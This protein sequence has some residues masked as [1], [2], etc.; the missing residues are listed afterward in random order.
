MSDATKAWEPTPEQLALKVGDEADYFGADGREYSGRVYREPYRNGGGMSWR[1]MLSLPWDSSAEVELRHVRPVRKAEPAKPAPPA[2]QNRTAL[3]S[4][5]DGLIVHAGGDDPQIDHVTAAE[6]VEMVR[7]HRT[8]K[9]VRGWAFEVGA[10]KPVAQPD[11]PVDASAKFTVDAMAKCV[12]RTLRKRW[13]AAEENRENFKAN[14]LDYASADEATKRD[15]L[16]AAYREIF[17]VEIDGKET[18]TS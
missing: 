17:G 18:T 14:G 6:L 9:Q 4:N 1:V 3:H 16:A 10:P 15:E 13:E 5:G 2:I 12:K 11:P 7:E 8:R